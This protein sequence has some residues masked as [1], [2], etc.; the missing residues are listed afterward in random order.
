MQYV[1]F[2]CFLKTVFFTFF[3]NICTLLK[4]KMVSFFENIP[5]AQVLCGSRHVIAIPKA[6]TNNVV[7]NFDLSLVEKE[8]EDRPVLYT[9]GWGAYGQLGT[10][11]R[12]SSSTPLPV[13]ESSFQSQRSRPS[14]RNASPMR[15][16][17]SG[18]GGEVVPLFNVVSVACGY[19]HTLLALKLTSTDTFNSPN[20]DLPLYTNPSE[21][22]CV[23]A[24]GWNQFGQC[25]VNPDSSGCVSIPSRVYFLT[26][27]HRTLKKSHSGVNYGSL[28]R[29][30]PRKRTA[31][32]S[33]LDL[34][35]GGGSGSG[36][37]TSSDPIGAHTFIL[38][39]TRTPSLE[40]GIQ[41]GGV[42]GVGRSEVRI[43][44]RS[45]SIDEKC[46]TASSGG[47][48]SITKFQ[49]FRTVFAM[50]AGG[51]HSIISASSWEDGAAIVCSWGRGD[52]GQL[53][54]Y[55]LGCNDIL[56][57]SLSDDGRIL[58]HDR[59]VTLVLFFC[60]VLLSFFCTDSFSYF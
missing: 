27:S 51:R 56:S 11:E 2:I 40:E 52:D 13:R 36:G 37:V 18:G 4:N 25:G 14:S 35:S 43:D 53:G 1:S 42:G 19:R 48:H 5:I 32:A 49:G 16:S 45:D 22:V 50:G 55:T 33:S 34:H 44:S 6:S 15:S 59:Y 17:M 23:W 38:S 8:E 47:K 21:A 20:S 29:V 28:L 3:L 9:W 57:L 7:V 58:V 54:M 31:S 60:F 24:W 39:R 41:G 46:S 30:S 10:G 26:D 12:V